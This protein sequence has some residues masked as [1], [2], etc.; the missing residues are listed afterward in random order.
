MTYSD[1]HICQG[2]LKLTAPGYRNINLCIPC[3]HTLRGYR[4]LSPQ[5]RANM[6]AKQE[7]L[8]RCLLMAIKEEEVKGD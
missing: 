7:R 1:G 3:A 4:R 5:E 2:C 8:M 6:A